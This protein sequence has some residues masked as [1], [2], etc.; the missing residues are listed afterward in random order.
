VKA[1]VPDVFATDA[2]VFPHGL[3]ARQFAYMV[4]DGMTPMQAIQSATSV[5]RTYMD[6]TTDVGTLQVR[7]FGDLIAVRGN[8]LF[9][10]TTLCSSRRGDQGRT[11]FKLPQQ[12]RGGSFPKGSCQNPGVARARRPGS[13]VSR[14]CGRRPRPPRSGSAACARHRHQ[15]VAVLVARDQ[16][17]HHLPLTT[18]SRNRPGS[19]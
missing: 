5:A 6:A 17:H 9:D 16:R 1:G 7:K 12:M 11:D 18:C 3:N 14:C 19:R 4:E 15:V 8:P 13:N 10:I 2:G